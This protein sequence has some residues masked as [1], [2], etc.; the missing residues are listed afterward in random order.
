MSL[1]SVDEQLI[2][3]LVMSDE[4]VISS[5][6]TITKSVLAADR[7]TEFKAAVEKYSSKR[8]EELVDICGQ[9]YKI[10]FKALAWQRDFQSELEGLKGRIE[11]LQLTL[12]ES[13]EQRLAKRMNRLELLQVQ[14]NLQKCMTACRNSLKAFNLA[15]MASLHIMDRKFEDAIRQLD[16]LGRQL[17]SIEDFSFSRQLSTLSLYVC[18]FFILTNKK[19]KK[20][21]GFQCKW[22]GFMDLPWKS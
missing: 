9:K 11:E 21:N 14:L 13:C 18:V 1:E 6:G 12:S 10:F 7:L 19:S 17:R 8:Q 22:R 15:Q 4:S 16:A 20:S 5:I 3:Q 2:D